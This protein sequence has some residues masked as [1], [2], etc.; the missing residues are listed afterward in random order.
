MF[1]SQAFLLGNISSKAN[2]KELYYYHIM[3]EIKSEKYQVAQIWRNEGTIALIH[4]VHR[5][6]L[7][8]HPQGQ[9]VHKFSDGRS[10][11][12]SKLC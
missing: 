10:T 2:I 3:N 1:S 8:R 5:G 9:L 7:I 6:K 4:D 12:R 11:N